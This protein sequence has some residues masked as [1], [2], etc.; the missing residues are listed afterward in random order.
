[1]KK[2]IAL[3]LA[4][5]LTSLFAAEVAG[6]DMN[7]EVKTEKAEVK[8]VKAKTVKKAKKAKKAKKENM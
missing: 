5:S 8:S 6:T 2:I 1:M 7:A 3:V 4:L